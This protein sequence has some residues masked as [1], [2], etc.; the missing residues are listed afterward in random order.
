MH[1]TPIETAAS[2]PTVSL[3][4]RP[5]SRRGWRGLKLRLGIGSRLALGLA[6]VAAV[7]L[8]GHGLATQ[9]TRE[10]VEAVR[11]M[12]SEHEPLARRASSV[13]DSLVAYDR[14][15]GEY[16]QA[17]R[18]SDFGTITAASDALQSALAA[19]YD[20]NPPPALTPASARLRGQLLH[21]IDGGRQL[22]KSARQR[23]AW[24]DARNAA[25]EGLHRRIASAGGTG[26][27]INGN[28]VVAQRS[29]SEL[30]VAIDAIRG[31][32]SAP[33]LISRREQ[34]FSAVLATHSEELSHS[35]GKAWL[36]L[37]R[38]DFAEA[39]R[40]RFAIERFDGAN[41]P[42]RR[43]LLEESATLTAGVEEQLQEP[44]RRGLLQ[45]AEHAATSA[46]IAE[47]T[48]T[49]TG[50]AVLGVVLLVWVVLALGISLPVRRLTAAT[51][52][53][54]TGNRGARAP[55]GG[56][57]E[58][59]ELAESFN[60]MADH[61]SR[62][63]A[64]L[65]AHQAELERHVAERTR[66]LHH[67][68]HHDPLTQLPNRR[69]LSARL[70]SALSRAS[71][72]GQ[73][74]ALLFVDVDNFKSIN[75]TLGHNFGDRVLQGIAKR[76]QTAA[77]TNGLLARLGGDEFTVLIE[78][79]KSIEEVESRAAQIVTTLQQPLTIDG[80]AL[81]TS[82]SVGASLYPD[83]ADDAEELLR[84]ADVALFRAK[85]LGRNRFALYRPALYDAAAQRFRLEQSLRKAVEAGDLMLMFQPQ[86]ALHT[87]EVTGL[88]ALLRW[89][90]PDG[91]IATATE[92]IHIAEKTGLIH[93][94]TDWVLRSATSTVAAWRA[95]GWHRACVAINV[96]PPQ[97]FESDFVGHVA[98]ALEVTGL[99]ASALE[100][101]LTETVFQ[102]GPTTIDAL[103][104]LREMGV[105]IALDDFGI[106]YSSLTSLEQLPITR[107]KLDRMLVEGVD[108]NPRSAAIVRSIVA[109]CHGLGLQVV[110]EGVERPTQLEF[111]S[112][113]GPLGVQGYLLAYP[114]EAHKAED[115]SRA[116]TARAR[117]ILEAAAAKSPHSDAVDSSLVFVGPA[118]GRKRTN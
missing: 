45:A 76:L 64:E 67:L 18:S 24:V 69:Q 87:F 43:D 92:F 83:H 86:V 12:Q 30:E 117:S 35:P 81:A 102:T 44:A 116:A 95:Q 82:A 11:S 10:A 103:R 41:G 88:E 51:R 66:Q 80:R 59:A 46:E 110:A 2:D 93:E 29:L 85:E 106:G 77:G 118:T 5:E 68:A 37:V 84:A 96:S 73:R 60:T 4:S 65:R 42:A 98:R 40:L 111:L 109:L 58:I 94:L 74:I 53:L 1:Q 62:A 71:A 52:L 101:E 36:E 107:V 25:L 104:R 48:L 21:H 115:E 22:A 91:R 15:V 108:T 16:L 72:T 50:A 34:D 17:G 63:E 61:I 105:S 7:I 114:V 97:F 3:P 31:N 20:T 8:V 32:V 33:G 113:C 19:Y 70:G 26:L 78:D 38:E 47:H 79:V 90:K 100:L 6:A 9:T 56:S 27:A 112:H 14:V 54:A 57:A 89:R 99:P 75:D 23:A 39:V 13:L 28:Q 55:R 49:M